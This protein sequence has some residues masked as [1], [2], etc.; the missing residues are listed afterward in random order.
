MKRGL[1]RLVARCE[2]NVSIWRAGLQ[3]RGKSVPITLLPGPAPVALHSS[4]AAR[5]RDGPAKIRRQGPGW[6]CSTIAQPV[7]TLAPR[8]A[9]GRVEQPRVEPVFAD[10]PATLAGL[11]KKG[12]VAWATRCSGMLMHDAVIRQ[13]HAS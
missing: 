10:E 13:A 1:A 5:A 8:T 11:F 12:S 6:S 2:A 7:Q 4:P 3:S 9:E